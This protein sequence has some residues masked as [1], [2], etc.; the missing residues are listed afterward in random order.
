MRSRQSQNRMLRCRGDSQSTIRER[1][2]SVLANHANRRQ[3]VNA[4]YIAQAFD[5]LAECQTTI[6]AALWNRIRA[7]ETS[8]LKAV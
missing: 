8:R 4:T 2:R 1:D 7:G 6:E 3:S 5:H